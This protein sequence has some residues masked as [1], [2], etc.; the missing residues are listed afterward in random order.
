MPVFCSFKE[1][2]SR[3][4]TRF[5]ALLRAY[6]VLHDLLPVSFPCSEPTTF[7]NSEGQ[8]KPLLPAYNI[9]QQ[10]RTVKT[11]VASLQHF[12]QFIA[13]FIPLLGSYTGLRWCVDCKQS[14]AQERKKREKPL[15]RSYTVL[16]RF[17]YPNLSV[18]SK[19]VHGFFTVFSLFRTENCGLFCVFPTVFF[20]PRQERTR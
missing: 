19:K 9:L 6:D 16:C 5:I 18:R 7:Y 17:I 8:W 12:T 11:L 4:I 2:R 14:A 13:R 3:F 20:P 15:P 1:R 10:W